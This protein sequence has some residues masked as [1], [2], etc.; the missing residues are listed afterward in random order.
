MS[1][2][3]GLVVEAVAETI[4]AVAVVGLDGPVTVKLL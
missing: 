2:V 1:K 3:F 4:L